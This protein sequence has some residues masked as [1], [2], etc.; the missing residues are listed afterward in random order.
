MSFTA[1]VIATGEFFWATTDIGAEKGR[2][3]D[4]HLPLDKTI[5]YM[6]NFL[7]GSLVGRSFYVEFSE[8]ETATYH[9]SE[10][11]EVPGDIRLIP[12]RGKKAAEESTP[13]PEP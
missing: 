9:G 11:D 8:S 6:G 12:V 1:K 4:A 7:P 2:F 3:R 10:L 5:Y 13:E